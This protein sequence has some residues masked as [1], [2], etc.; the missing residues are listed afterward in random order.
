[1]LYFFSLLRKRQLL[2]LYLYTF[3]AHYITYKVSVS[4][5]YPHKF[6]PF[7]LVF[8]AQYLYGKKVEFLFNFSKL[9]LLTLV[10]FLSQTSQIHIL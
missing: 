10:T 1:M 7:F 3:L 6:Y 2:F 4:F 9:K 8:G 5:F